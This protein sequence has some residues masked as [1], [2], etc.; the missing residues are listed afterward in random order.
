MA[1][2][3]EIF[4]HEVPEASQ[5]S[6]EW[7]SGIVRCEACGSVWTAAFHVPTYEMMG[8]LLRCPR[9]KQV[10]GEVDYEFTKDIAEG[11]KCQPSPKIN[12]H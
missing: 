10:A 11:F 2:V 8:R 3:V 1:E 12:S 7:D 5:D 6:L 4:I 9:C